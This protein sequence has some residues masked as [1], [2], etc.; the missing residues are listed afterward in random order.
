A[1]APQRGRLHRASLEH[2]GSSA[3]LAGNGLG[4]STSTAR[5]AVSVCD[6]ILM[7]EVETAEEVEQ[8]PEVKKELRRAG[9]KQPEKKVKAKATDKFWFVTHA[10]LLLGCA[11]LYYIIGSK[12]LP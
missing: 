9:E 5:K 3:S 2:R 4:R 12:F 1:R 10:L 8:K 11:A 6:L 7:P